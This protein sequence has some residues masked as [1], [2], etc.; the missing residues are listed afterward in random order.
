MDVNCHRINGAGAPEPAGAGPSAAPG[1][2][3][4]TGARDGGAGAAPGRVGPSGPPVPTGADCAGRPDAARV[5]AL[6]LET[7]DPVSAETLA[8]AA[9]LQRATVL[10]A[11][12]GYEQ[13][14]YLLRIPGQ[15]GEF[16]F[17]NLWVL[18]GGV[19]EGRSVADAVRGGLLTANAGT[20]SAGQHLAE[21]SVRPNP[22]GAVPV[23]PVTDNP[24]L[25][26][27]GLKELV[28]ALLVGRYP[29]ALG[30]AGMAKLLDGRSSGAIRN[31]ADALCREGLVVCTDLAVR[32]YA[33][34]RPGPAETDFPDEAVNGA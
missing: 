25:R 31:A 11:L 32:R 7:R 9:K 29:D 30:P 27:G 1:P 28:L 12:L 23:G 10:A 24:V 34:L 19:R 13:A 21:Q 2:R 8:R 15:A 17:P 5:W 26:K 20:E 14:G 18:A 16:P 3:G 4:G 22:T 6:L 33:A